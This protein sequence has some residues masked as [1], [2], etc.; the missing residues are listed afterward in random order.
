MPP[1]RTICIYGAGALGGAV[2]AKLASMQ[3][4]DATISVVARGEHLDAIRK[5]GLDLIEHGVETPRNVRITATDDP[6][7]LPP[8]DLVITGLK[9]HQLTDAAPG[10]ARLLKENTRV[11]MI[12]NGIP[13][14][15][16]YQDAASGHA[17]RQIESLDPGGDLWR[18]IGPQRVIGCVA[19][20]GGRIAAPG[21]V[22]LT[23]RGS[24]I[25]GEPTGEITPD[26][27]ALAALFSDAGVEVRL[28]TRIRDDIWSKLMGNTSFNPISAITRLPMQDIMADP[29]L[30]EMISR[31]MLE[32]QAVGEALS[33]KIAISV[34]Q[35]LQ[36]SRAIGAVKTSMLQDLL[37][38]KPLEIVPIV[39]IVPTLARLVGI[40]T[41]AT[42]AV[43][44][45]VT[46]LDRQ[47]RSA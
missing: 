12:L 29:A 46:A 21:K 36:Q 6:N 33:A 31:I 2:A 8:Q 43:L 19:H 38:G 42:D 22:H 10:I 28:S 15:Y 41:P 37:A 5:D 39:G 18:L 17:D 11:V 16:F 30:T 3:G 47:N 4:G 44:T 1:Y 20:Q 26:I 27:E 7:D 23:N 13:W 24:F 45:L 9:G 14:W 25:L 34:E 35:R 32:V 40:A